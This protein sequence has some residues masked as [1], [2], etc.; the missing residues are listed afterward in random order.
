MKKNKKSALKEIRGV[1][2]NSHLNK[3][4]IRKNEKD[5]SIDKYVEEIRNGNRIFLSKSITLIESNNITYF[6]KGQEILRRLLPFSGNSIRIGITGVPGVGKSTF[7]ENLGKYYTGKGHKVAVLAID[8]S[9]S[10][11][12]GSI[13]GDK[14]RMEELSRDENAYIRPTSSGNTLGGVARKTRE[15][16]FLCEAAGFDKILVETVGVGQSETLVESMTDFFLLLKLAGAGDELQGI[17]RGIIEMADLIV[18]NKA[19]GDNMNSAKLAQKSFQSALHYYPPKKNYWKPKVLLASALNNKG[20]KEI[21]TKI[22]EFIKLT[23]SNSYF[24]KKRIEQDKYWFYES[25]KRQLETSFFQHK[26]I[27]DKLPDLLSKME[28]NKI[29]A[30][31]AAENLLKIFEAKKH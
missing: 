26:K 4:K 13:L 1:E 18:I 8:P 17:K 14:T 11:S 5:I 3:K 28:N 22:D 9:S 10:I 23:K 2:Q 12:K 27:K 31:E 21:A 30:F 19:E 6:K 7:I 29:T 24:D 16:I 15:T 20:T 25:I